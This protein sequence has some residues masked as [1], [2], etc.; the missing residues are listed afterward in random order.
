MKISQ[1]YS[2]IQKLQVPIQQK[3]LLQWLAARGLLK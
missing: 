3:W 1:T 2:K